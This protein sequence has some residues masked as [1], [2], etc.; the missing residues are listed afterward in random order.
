MI[1]AAGR[2][3]PTAAQLQLSGRFRFAF[4]ERDVNTAA[5]RLKFGGLKKA[6]FRVMALAR[7][8]IK[9]KGAAKPRLAVAK[10]NPGLSLR[11]IANLPGATRTTAGTQR[12]SR[13]RFLPG[14]G[15]RAAVAGEISERDR[16]RV[17][18]RLREIKAR[19]PSAPGTPPHTH[20]GLL[21]RNIFFDLDRTSESVVI[22]SFVPAARWLPVLHEFSGV[23]RMAAWLYVPRFAGRY[24]PILAYHRV[25]KGP[26][27]R[28]RWQATRATRAVP[29]PA[30]PY[31]GAA[32][33][34]G[35][36]SGQIAAEFKNRFR[37]AGG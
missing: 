19:E 11:E 34:A 28:D 6:G 25:G 37:V 14:S 29:Y 22:G 17:L 18:E 5:N 31:M 2:L 20:T 26:K 32:V 13:G 7:R 1:P 4:Y 36:R 33:R 8:S 15:K 27:K 21:R 9:R 24:S 35:I 16:A 3:I 12:D 23:Q 30:R 10:N